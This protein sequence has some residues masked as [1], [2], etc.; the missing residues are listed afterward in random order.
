MRSIRIASIAML[1]LAILGLAAVA[2]PRAE[3]KDKKHPVVRGILARTHKVVV[4]AWK[5]VKKGNDGKGA[6]RHAWVHQKAAAAALRNDKPALAAKLSLLARAEARKAIRANKGEEPKDLAT[7][8]PEETKAAEGAAEADVKAAVEAEEKAA[9]S[10][11]EILKEEPK[12][13][14]PKD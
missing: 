6:F 12:A 1:V 11:E 9:P 4:H 14:E 3:A 8:T 2:T 13:E 5:A 10:E 7:D